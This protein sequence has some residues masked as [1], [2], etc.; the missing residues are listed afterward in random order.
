MALWHDKNQLALEHKLLWCNNLNAMGTFFASHVF[1]NPSKNYYYK[2]N[3]QLS[4]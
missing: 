4:Q 3:D 2:A 1:S